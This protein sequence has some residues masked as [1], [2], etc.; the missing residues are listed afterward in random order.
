MGI[1]LTLHGSEIIQL[2]AI[3]ERG[4]QQI[5]NAN[6]NLL[7]Y[8][9]ATISK[10]QTLSLTKISIQRFLHNQKE[11]KCPTC[12]GLKLVAQAIDPQLP[13]RL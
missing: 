8:Y 2:A 9:E 12:F 10:V 1:K 4:M 7:S 11:F 13:K 6:S 3:L 5:D